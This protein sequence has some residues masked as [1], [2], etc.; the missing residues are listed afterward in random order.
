MMRT[1]NSQA[2]QFNP[3]AVNAAQIVNEG[4][5]SDVL[6]NASHDGL[7]VS[8]PSNSDLSCGTHS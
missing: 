2:W 3:L 7:V 8:F 4:V 6:H 5:K 1:N